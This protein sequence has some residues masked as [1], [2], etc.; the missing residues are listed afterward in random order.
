MP[1]FI[2]SCWRFEPSTMKPRPIPS[3]NPCNDN[4]YILRMQRFF[5]ILEQYLRLCYGCAFALLRAR[6]AGRKPER[7][8]FEV[9]SGND[10]QVRHA[11]VSVGTRPR[12]TGLASQTPRAQVAGH[13]LTRYF[14][15]RAARGPALFARRRLIPAVRLVR[16]STSDPFAFGA[17][18]WP[19]L[20]YNRKRLTGYSRSERP[21]PDDSVH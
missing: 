20:R 1:P 11:D 8:T 12:R 5:N 9:P 3:G 4:A 21:R 18:G 7:R 19:W 6:L 14:Q 15:P 17:S 10:L 2:R 16:T 13:R